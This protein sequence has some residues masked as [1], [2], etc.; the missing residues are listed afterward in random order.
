LDVSQCD[1]SEPEGAFVDAEDW[2]DG[3]LALFAESCAILSLL[4]G[5]HGDTPGLGHQALCLLRLWTEA[6]GSVRMGLSDRHER[7]DALILQGLDGGAVC[8]S[9]VGRHPFR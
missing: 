2:F 6:I 4:H 8:V 9:G 3:L 5:I 7:V 1:L